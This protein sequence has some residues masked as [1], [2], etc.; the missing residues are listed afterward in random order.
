MVSVVVIGVGVALIVGDNDDN[1]MPGELLVV[2][3]GVSLIII[4][5]DGT[6]WFKDKGKTT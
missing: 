1:T 4:I 3:G 5:I 2:L 6:G